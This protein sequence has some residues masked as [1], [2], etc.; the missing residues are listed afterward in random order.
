MWEELR[1]RFGVNVIKKYKEILKNEEMTKRS[2]LA[3]HRAQHSTHA[4]VQLGSS[5]F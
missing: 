1:R 3:C 4:D 5:H 2:A